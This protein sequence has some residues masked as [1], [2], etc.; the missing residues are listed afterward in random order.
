MRGRPRQA[1]SILN[2][3]IDKMGFREDYNLIHGMIIMANL[4]NKITDVERMEFEAKLNDKY[5]ELAY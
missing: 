4:L 2:R 5:E 1:I 3:E